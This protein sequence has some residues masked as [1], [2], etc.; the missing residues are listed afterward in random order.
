M[1][2]ENY[3]IN[4]TTIPVIDLLKDDAIQA[5]K[6]AYGKYHVE[7]DIYDD[8]LN[9]VFTY[10]P[11]LMQQLAISRLLDAYAVNTHDLDTETTTRTEKVNEST[12]Q[13]STLTAGTSVT[14]ANSQD[15]TQKTTG[16]VKDDSTQTGTQDSMIDI[17][18]TSNTELTGS[19][20]VA[21]NYA[22]P[23]Q[24]IDGVT[25]EFEYNLDGTPF[26]GTSNVQ[27]ATENFGSNSPINSGESSN[28]QTTVNTETTTGNI[29]TNDVT[30]TD[31]M[32]G[33]RTLTNS[34]SDNSNSNTQVTADNVTTE[35]R[36]LQATNKQY[37]Y[38]VAAFLD[39]AGKT[40]A[41]EI[42]TNRFS[43][44]VGIQ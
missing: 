25:K 12:N 44:V 41:F 13:L 31:E 40:V 17:T 3:T 4:E 7:P 38:E 18:N 26:L 5:L 16:T 39:V 2:W 6:R 28:Q 19:H 11:I 10:F 43:W 32:T 22:M 21:L 1:R 20:N 33:N 27:G 15:N 9:D 35:S 37:A 23:E 42:W 34:G 29:Q 24:S 30:V 8:F 36:E 14:E